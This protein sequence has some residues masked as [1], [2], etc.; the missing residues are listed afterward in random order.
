MGGAA[1]EAGTNG[2][3]GRVTAALFGLRG[4]RQDGKELGY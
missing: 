3:V 4:K 2:Q 1:K